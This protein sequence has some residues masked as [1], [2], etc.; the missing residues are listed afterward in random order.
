MLKQKLHCTKY[1]ALFV[2]TY[3]ERNLANFI[4]ALLI[5]YMIFD[6]LNIFS[7]EVLQMFLAWQN[8][9]SVNRKNI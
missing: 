5:L 1:K 7:T 6:K 9:K 3:I 2:M 8:N 4:L